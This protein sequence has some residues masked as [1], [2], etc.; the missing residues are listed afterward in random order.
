MIRRVAGVVLAGVFAVFLSA[1]TAWAHGGPI[2]LQVQS[3]GGQGVNVTVTYARDHHMVSEE[4]RMS[5]TA[6]SG[7]GDTV[8]PVQLVASNEGQAFYQSRKPL[9]VG[10]WTVTVTATHPSP[11]TTTIDLTSAVL[12]KPA[13]PPVSTD[14]PTL[15]VVA[16][17]VPVALAAAAIAVALAIRRRRH[18]GV[19]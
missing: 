4:V 13:A 7:A 19:A 9:P 5:Y 18:A 6:V 10:N 14:N 3:D 11:A 16:I 2:E 1:G 17:A 12:A 15:G 8:G